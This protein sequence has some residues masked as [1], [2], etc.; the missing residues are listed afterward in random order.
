MKTKIEL[1]L[2][3]FTAPNFVLAVNPDPV[4]QDFSYPLS[5]IDAVT[6]ERMCDDFRNSVFEKAKKSPPPRDASR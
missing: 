3:P 2:K 6:L 1:D 5:I 4:G